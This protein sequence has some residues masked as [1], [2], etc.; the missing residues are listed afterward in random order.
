MFVYIQ[1]M[2]DL[3]SDVTPGGGGVGHNHVK[4]KKYRNFVFISSLTGKC[5]VQK[6]KYGHINK[7][8]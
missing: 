5:A 3:I 4:N 8:K 6:F 1:D 2:Y 7:P